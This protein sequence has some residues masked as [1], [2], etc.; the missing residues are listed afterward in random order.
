MYISMLR[1]LVGLILLI[2]TACGSLALWYQLYDFPFAVS[3]FVLTCWSV[4]GIACVITLGYRYRRRMRN[5]LIAYLLLGA[6][7]LIWWQTVTPSH[8]RDWADDVAYLLKSEMQGNQVTLY[9]V[10]NFKWRSESDYTANW[11]TRHYNLEQLVSADLILS[12]WMG[13]HIAHTLVSFGF[14][15]GQQLVFSLEIR[16]ERHESFSA[17]GGLFRQFEQVVIAADERD[18]ILTRSNARNED[19]YLYPLALNPQQLRTLF[20]GYLTMAESLRT[21]PQFYNTLTSNCTTI[22]FDLA[23][24]IAPGIP[25]DYRL[26][27]SGHFA[28]YAYDQ[29]ALIPGYSYS[30]LQTSGYINVRAQQANE[31]PNFSR[32]I[33]ND[34]AAISKED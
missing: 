31:D 34:I 7:L 12:Y 5:L 24:Q 27:L 13:P 20:L 17:I 15:N 23:R 1:L 33:R 25:L 4:L 16:K 19:V 9:N 3:L 11:Q 8:Q 28:E 26:L 18:I 29:G 14:N 2:S 32:A 30:Q 6:I 10:R 22:V 21:T